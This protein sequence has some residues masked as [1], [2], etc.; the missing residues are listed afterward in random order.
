MSDGQRVGINF[1]K[2][3]AWTWLSSN[4]AKSLGIFEETG[5]LETGKNADVVLWSTDPF[6]TYSQAELVFID[7]GVAF[8]R[9]KPETLG[10]K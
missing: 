2:A 3:D 5:S 8:D 9:S 1:T 7:G 6:S 10:D 4:A